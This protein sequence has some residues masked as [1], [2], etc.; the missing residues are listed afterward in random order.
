M[1]RQIKLVQGNVSTARPPDTGP[2]RL[3]EARELLQGYEA[4]SS[5]V[6][7][8]NGDSIPTAASG[9]IHWA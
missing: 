2:Q 7:P 3:A 4:R 8:E 6:T 1:G 5:L 9:I